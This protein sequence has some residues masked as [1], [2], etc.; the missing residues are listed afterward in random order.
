[1]AG[2]GE[3]GAVSDLYKCR[4]IGDGNINYTPSIFA[5]KASPSEKSEAHMTRETSLEKTGTATAS[6][7]TV[8]RPNSAIFRRS[9]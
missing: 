6:R 9:A 1:M 2:S 8:V 7:A 3:T 5:C 4:N